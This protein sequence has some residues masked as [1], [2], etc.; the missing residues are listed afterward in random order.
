MYCRP[1]R[2]IARFAG[3]APSALHVQRRRP[4]LD[5]DLSSA[6]CA[7]PA[8]VEATETKEAFYLFV[9]QSAFHVVPKRAFSNAHDVDVARRLL[10]DALGTK[11]VLSERTGLTR[12]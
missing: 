3:P 9:Q 4:R 11:A 2:P 7:W 5:D 1:A 12:R 10:S 8:A 6:Q